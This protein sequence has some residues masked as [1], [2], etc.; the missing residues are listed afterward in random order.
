MTTT[1]RELASALG[2]AIIIGNEDA[3]VSGVE[4]HS[5]MIK[6]GAAFVA[7]TGFTRDGNEFAGDAIERGAAA[8]IT[9]REGDLPVPQMIVSDARAALA[10]LAAYFYDYK[11]NRVK[12]V[13]VTGTN[14]K[15]TSCFLIRSIL[16][17]RGKRVGLITSLLYDTGRDKIAGDRTT[18]ESLDVFRLL[19]AMQHNWCN[20]AVLEISS[21]ALVLHRVRNVNVRVALFTNFTRDHLDFHK[22]M[23]DY[24]AAKTRLLDMVN[25]ETKWAVVNYD[26]PEFR[27]LIDRMKCSYMS[28]SL[29]DPGADIYLENY[30]LRPTGTRFEIHTPVAN[31]VVH[32]SLVGRYNLYNAL[33]ATGASMAA[34]ADIDS[35]V[36]GLEN[37]QI[38]PGRLERIQVDAPYT[39]F[40]DFAHTPDALIRT[41][42][43]L[44]ELSDGRLL[45]IFGCGGDRDRGKR[46]LMAEAVTANSDYTI[47]TTDNP[48]TE[49][50]NQ[51]FSDT[52]AGFVDGADTIT[53]EDRREAIQ[54]ALDTA[55]DTDVV[56]V[57]GKGD[58]SYLDIKGT[59][60][61]W[62]DRN[63]IIEEMANR[64]YKA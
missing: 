43:A 10:D 35:V 28:Y 46:P 5:R 2:G 38:V 31:R 53:I 25:E 50:P 11:N 4:Y 32:M 48:R 41:I 22:D 21:H 51:I 55:K 29:S 34:G 6:P 40:I 20:N 61:P 39:V 17:A 37:A 52:E 24:L 49:D 42:E 62:S 63:V 7:I 1:L 23:D 18:P 26:V 19:Y 14:G 13:G 58:E 44:R 9:E 8:I 64:G 36:D 57:A 54:H 59:K 3:E 56:L 47:L 30:Q 33:A 60:H 12:V 27:A 15:T 16:E 45:T